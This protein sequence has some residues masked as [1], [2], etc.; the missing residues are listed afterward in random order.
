MSFD[1]WFQRKQPEQPYTA[2]YLED[3]YDAAVLDCAAFIEGGEC[4]MY[5]SK[6]ERRELA[7]A[8]RERY[9]LTGEKS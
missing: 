7:E 8:I 5:S 9:N 2:K 4:W 3:A 1:K 6:G